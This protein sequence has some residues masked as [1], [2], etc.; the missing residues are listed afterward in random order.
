MTS[1]FDY[2]RVLNAIPSHLYLSSCVEEKGTIAILVYFEA[3]TRSGQDKQIA[4]NVSS[5]EPA[6]INNK[7]WLS[8]FNW[9]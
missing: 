3:L 4:D 7:I 5:A 9:M 8:F 2:G 6:I 1:L